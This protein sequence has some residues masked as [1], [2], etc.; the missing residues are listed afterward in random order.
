[1]PESTIVSDTAS[2]LAVVDNARTLE[3]YHL[4][5]G[6]LAF[7]LEVYHM[8][9]AGAAVSKA[10]T[11]HTYHLPMVAR[12]LTFMAYHMAPVAA[13]I[14]PSG[15][16]TVQRAFSIPV[17]EFGEDVGGTVDFTVE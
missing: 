2:T 5:G 7:T 9:P 14:T 11:L 1:M 3:S 8:A 16:T 12:G 10:R 13:P 6:E 15:D 4:L 17:F